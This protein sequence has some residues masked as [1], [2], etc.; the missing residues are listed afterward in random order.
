MSEEETAGSSPPLRAG[1]GM[2]SLLG[3]GLTSIQSFNWFGL[4]LIQTF[5]VQAFNDLIGIGICR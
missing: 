2:T 4:S 5:L 3:G 1:V